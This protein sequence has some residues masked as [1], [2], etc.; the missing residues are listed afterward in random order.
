MKLEPESFGFIAIRAVWSGKK[1]YSK[2]FGSTKNF[3]D[4]TFEEKLIAESK[5]MAIY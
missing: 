3:L 4:T 5:S 2:H 1:R